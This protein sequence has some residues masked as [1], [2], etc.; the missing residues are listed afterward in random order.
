MYEK[1]KSV[2]I[3]IGVQNSKEAL[4]WYQNLLGDIEI[5]EPMPGLFELKLTDTLW[6]QLDDTGYL[7]VGGESTI[8]R[9]E[10]DDIDATYE[11]VV[12]IAF[13]VEQISLVEGL[14]KYF[15]F[16]D[17]SGNRLSF[18]QLL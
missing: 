5:I 17:K 18:V 7:A 3:G 2:T 15:D 11:K 1:L 16:K 12:K 9:F 10:T 14:I 6:L 4:E 13:D 8:I